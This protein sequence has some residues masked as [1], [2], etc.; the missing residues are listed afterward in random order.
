VAA[1]GCSGG[2]LG[3]GRA[4]DV[5]SGCYLRRAV[6]TIESCRRPVLIVVIGARTL[7]FFRAET[8]RSKEQLPDTGEKT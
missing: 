2:L 6:L 1:R 4:P 8:I 5:V 3:L 7:R